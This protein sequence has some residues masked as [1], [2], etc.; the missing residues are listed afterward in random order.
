[1]K[2]IGNLNQQITIL[3]K[4]TSVSL[5]GRG[6]FGEIDEDHTDTINITQNSV[7]AF[8]EEISGGESTTNNK[9]RAKKKAKFTIRKTSFAIAMTDS[10][11]F[12]GFEYDIT[13]ILN[14]SQPRNNFITILGESI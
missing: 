8:V 6:A 10:I 5:L 1:M 2:K 13:D 4:T 9:E 3:N 12:N 7:Y 14:D 11:L